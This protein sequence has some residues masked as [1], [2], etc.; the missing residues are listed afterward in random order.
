M[1]TQNHSTPF[2]VDEV[3]LL[4]KTRTKPSERIKIK[5]SQEAYRTLLDHWDV[6]TIDLQEEFKILLLNRGHAV[7]GIA[8]ISVGGLTGTVVDVR[9][10]LQICL[11]AN[12]CS[13]ILSHNHPSG[14]SNPSEADISITKKIKDAG[15]MIDI[16]V[17]DHLIVCQEGRYFSLADEGR[18]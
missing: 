13:V 15:M 12:C 4:Y 2:M 18:M 5:S 6:N 11:K 3:Q 16:K 10:I 7:L 9:K 14:N 8:T 1:K 17:L